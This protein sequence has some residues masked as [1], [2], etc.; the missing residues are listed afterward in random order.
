MSERVTDLVLIRWRQ[1][2]AWASAFEPTRRPKG[3]TN[4]VTRQTALNLRAVGL[5]DIV[6]NA[7]AVVP[8]VASIDEM[9]ESDG[10]STPDHPLS[11][12]EG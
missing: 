7:D 9:E 4:I 6:G 5:V 12:V 3:A 2:S 11:P 8:Q 1:T 10:T